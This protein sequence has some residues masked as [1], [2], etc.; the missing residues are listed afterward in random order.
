MTIWHCCLVARYGTEF[1]TIFLCQSTWRRRN[2]PKQADNATLLICIH[3]RMDCCESGYQTSIPILCAE[4]ENFGLVIPM[5]MTSWP[6][7]TAFFIAKATGSD[8]LS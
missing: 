4:S 2:P 7:F 1:Q 5:L 8:M 6:M 3:C